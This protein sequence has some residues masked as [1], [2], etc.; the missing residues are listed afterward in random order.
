M[1]QGENVRAEKTGGTISFVALGDVFIDGKIEYPD[2][3]VR[4]KKRERPES[5]FAL[6]SSFLKKADLRFCNL[7]AP[8]CNLCQKGTIFHG[9]RSAWSSDSKNAA[10]LKYAGFDVVS[11]ANNQMMSYGWAGVDRTIKTLGKNG[12]LFVGAGEN[13]KEATQPR[14]VHVKD[15]KIAFLAYYFNDVAPG[16]PIVR[17]RAD[18]EKPG[19]A[20]V[21]VSPLY[22]PPHV[23][24]QHLAL[25]KQTIKEARDISDVVVVSCHWGVPHLQTIAIH[26]TALGHMAIDLGA[27][28]VIGT[29]PHIIQGIEV[30]KNKVIAY[31]LANFG[32]DSPS[33]MPKESILLQAVIFDKK[34][35][36]VSFR[37]VLHNS[38]GQPEVL[39]KDNKNGGKIFKILQSL[40]KEFGTKLAFKIGEIRIEG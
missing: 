5:I 7:E 36:K 6:V 17:S 27:D 37:P 31:S 24:H 23:N 28:L 2:G 10:G 19:L 15:V 20:E 33:P 11:L 12:I 1:S 34:V 26:Q 4:Y 14:V 32:F 8:L 13:L 40:S 21:A 38:L 22:P 29:H 35:Q 25:F 9:R 18:E 39:G 16:I 3:T 30:Y